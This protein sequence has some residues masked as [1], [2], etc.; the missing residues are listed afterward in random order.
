MA[1]V[2]FGVH[3]VWSVIVLAFIVAMSICMG[4]ATGQKIRADSFN[5]K[6]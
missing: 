4:T 6:K 5:H 2:H 1:D 3:F